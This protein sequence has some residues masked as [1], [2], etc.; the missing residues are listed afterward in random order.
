MFK[1]FIN[2]KHPYGFSVDQPPPRS[3]SVGT[4][5]VKSVCINTDPPPKKRT[6]PPKKEAQCVWRGIECQGTKL[7]HPPLKSISQQYPKINPSSYCN[8]KCACV[9]ESKVKCKE[10][11]RSPQRKQTAHMNIP[12]NKNALWKRNCPNFPPF[13]ANNQTSINQITTEEPRLPY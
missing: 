5:A 2:Q 1:I 3:W 12:L 9:Q 11:E 6:P 4:K 10:R 8:P 13:A 7:R